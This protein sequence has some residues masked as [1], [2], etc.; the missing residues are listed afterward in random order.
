MT[1]PAIQTVPF[2]APSSP[3]VPFTPSPPWAPS[4]FPPILPNSPFVYDDGR[5]R[6]R[7]TDTTGEIS[8]CGT[9]YDGMVLWT[10]VGRPSFTM[11]APQP[12]F[13]DVLVTLG[14]TPADIPRSR[15]QFGPGGQWRA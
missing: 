15:P 6:I 2:A 1:A 8:I 7:I 3:V 12:D 9:N 11:C 14:I 4:P 5:T 13:A 10:E